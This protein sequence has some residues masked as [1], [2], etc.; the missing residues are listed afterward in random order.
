LINRDLI[1]WAKVHGGLWLDFEVSLDSK[2][3]EFNFSF[4]V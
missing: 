4:E 3:V 2:W 1:E